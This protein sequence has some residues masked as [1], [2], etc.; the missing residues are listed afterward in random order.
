MSRKRVNRKLSPIF[1]THRSLLD[2]AIIPRWILDRPLS[3][4]LLGLI[5]GLMAYPDA[6]GLSIADTAKYFE[7]GEMEMRRLIGEAAGVELDLGIAI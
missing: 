3:L 4:E 7:I 1:R 5:A 6:R 2:D